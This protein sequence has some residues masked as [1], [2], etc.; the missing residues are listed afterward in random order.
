MITPS[1]KVTLTVTFPQFRPPSFAPKTF[2]V[3]VTVPPAALVGAGVGVGVDEGVGVDVAA[4]VLVVC[5]GFV[6]VDFFEDFVGV[7]VGAAEEGAELLVGCGVV[8]V[9]VAASPDTPL[10]ELPNCG[11]VIANTP[12]NAPKVPVT[13]NRARFFI[14]S[15]YSP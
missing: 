6:V 4:G 9:V 8:V 11:G 2:P 13:T 14:I 12:P 15:P 3:T 1:V 5:E 10:A 7:G